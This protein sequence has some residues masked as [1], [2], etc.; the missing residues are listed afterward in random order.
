MNLMISGRK[1]FKNGNP[2]TQ[3]INLIIEP[4]PLDKR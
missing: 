4:N 2:G 3:Q 1:V